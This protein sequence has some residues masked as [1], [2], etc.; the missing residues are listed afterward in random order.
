MYTGCIK[1]VLLLLFLV[2]F[3]YGLLTALLRNTQLSNLQVCNLLNT[4]F[5]ALFLITFFSFFHLYITTSLSLMFG[6]VIVTAVAYKYFKLFSFL[7]ILLYYLLYTVQ[8]NISKQTNLQL[9]SFYVVSLI[10]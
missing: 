3:L 1:I 8:I 2:Q 9:I 10:I 4:R 7:S 6:H 5:C